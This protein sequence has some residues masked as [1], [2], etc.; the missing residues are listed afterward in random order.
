MTTF[1]LVPGAGGQG[2]YWH[3]VAAELERR[4]HAAVAVDL[5]TDDDSAG[6]AAYTDAVV[7]A[8]GSPGPWSSS[9]SRWA[10]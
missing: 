3:L 5:P 1:V 6:L 7:T 10:D 2:W 9:P 4:G 8:V